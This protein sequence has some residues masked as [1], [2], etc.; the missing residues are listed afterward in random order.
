MYG[1][2]NLASLLNILLKAF[3]FLNVVPVCLPCRVE[4]SREELLDSKHIL[5]SCW[6][7]STFFLSLYDNSFLNW[8]NSFDL[9]ITFSIDK[10]VTY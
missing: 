4:L 2:S 6:I 8:V 9:N 10:V 5:K 1:K 7:L 3:V